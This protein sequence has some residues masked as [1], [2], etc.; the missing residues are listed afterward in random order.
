MNGWTGTIVRL[1]A[2]EAEDWHQ[3]HN[4]D[5]DTVSARASDAIHFPRSEM[6]TRHWTEETAAKVS[7]G[8]STMLAIE[9][10]D[11][12]L[13]GCISAHSCDSRNGTFKYGVA[14]F[15]DHWRKGYA[16]EAVQLL[17]RYFFH[18]LRYEKAVASVY[19]FNESSIR[20]QERLGFIL[21]GRL[22]S[23]IFTN[24]SRHDELVFGLLRSEFDANL[25]TPNE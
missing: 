2:I 6:G 19:G 22:R 25:S 16:F 3:F 1:R 9:K 20:M 24:G 10:R 18:E 12:E 23:M 11:G 14:I 17:L 4:N 13:V 21:E 5:Q 15:R 8:D 7:T